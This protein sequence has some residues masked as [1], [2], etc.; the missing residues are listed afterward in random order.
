M[1]LLFDGSCGTISSALISINVIGEFFM[2]LSRTISSALQRILLVLR[3][4]CAVFEIL[5]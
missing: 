3:L 2:L 5:N 1:L 4:H